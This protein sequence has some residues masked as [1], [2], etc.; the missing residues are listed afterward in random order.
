ML[1][2]TTFHPTHM[3]AVLGSPRKLGDRTIS[4][5]CWVSLRFTQ[6][7]WLDG[8]SHFPP[9]G[10]GWVEVTKPNP[11]ISNCCWVSLRFTQPTW[12]HGYMGDR[13]FPKW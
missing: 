4:N 13:T 12:L 5:C 2:F 9:S 6:P 3:A 11:T 7:T 8:R 1:G 10:V